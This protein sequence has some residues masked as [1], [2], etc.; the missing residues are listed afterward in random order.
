MNTSSRL[1]N[2][3]RATALLA[4]V[5]GTALPALALEIDLPAE[6]ALYQQSDMPGYTL[7]LQ[8]CLMCH[9]AQYV[10]YQP[11]T[12]PRSY[13]EATVKK[14]KHPFGAPF[15]EGDI[16]A[17]VDYLTKTYGAESSA[18]NSGK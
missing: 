10:Q 1:K 4:S 7:T 18:A 14:M 8:N 13:W 3:F 6:T 16:P 5:C 12:S 15:P 2:L 9:S 17:M 11:K